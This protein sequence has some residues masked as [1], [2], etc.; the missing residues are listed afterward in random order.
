M[1][2]N[3]IHAKVEIIVLCNHFSDFGRTNPKFP[4]RAVLEVAPEPWSRIK[5]P[6]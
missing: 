4:A 5:T 1:S 3:V 2:Q 6:R